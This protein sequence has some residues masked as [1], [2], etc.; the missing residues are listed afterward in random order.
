MNKP[1]AMA[2][3]A[4]L[5]ASCAT[6]PTPLQGQF[7]ATTPKDHAA[8]GTQAVRWGGEIIKVDPKRDSTCF[9]VL[10]REL[11]A[12]ARPLSRD[13]SDGRFIA[14]RSGFYD[15]EVFERGRELTVVGHLTGTEHGKVGDFDYAYPHVDADA[16][17]LWPKRVAYARSP[18]YDPWMVGYGGGFGW[19]PYWGGPFWGG[20]TI[21]IR[22]NA[23]PHRGR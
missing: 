21:I 15:P 13:P 9:E 5:L 11:D 14:C 2:L 18:Y 10:A 22:D 23:G 19:G 1:L 3:T 17:Y 12:S 20:G 16:I 4:S 8:V 6:I 7:S